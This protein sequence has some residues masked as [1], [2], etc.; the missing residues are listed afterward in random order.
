MLSYHKLGFWEELIAASS[1]SAAIFWIILL[2]IFPITFIGDAIIGNL[3]LSAILGVA[4][5]VYIYLKN[6]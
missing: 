5:G 6:S 1:K 3:Q 2:V 4:V